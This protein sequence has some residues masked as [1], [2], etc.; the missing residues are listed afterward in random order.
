[1]IRLITKLLQ[2]Q[3]MGARLTLGNVYV[4]GG[5][6]CVGIS[7]AGVAKGNY[8]YEAAANFIYNDFQ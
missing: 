1:M 8:S 4:E 5:Y 6:K 2:Q 7:V 3:P